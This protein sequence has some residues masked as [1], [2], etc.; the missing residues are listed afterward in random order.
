MADPC[1]V[2]VGENGQIGRT[3]DG[4]DTWASVGPGTNPIVGIPAGYVPE[5]LS[6]DT[7]GGGIWVAVA[8][9]C[10]IWR[11]TDNAATWN[12]VAGTY[13]DN[14]T[15]SPRWQWVCYAGADTWLANETSNTDIWRSTDNGATWSAVTHGV[16]LQ[17]GSRYLWQI[18]ADT[19]NGIVWSTQGGAADY[20]ARSTDRG[21]TWEAVIQNPDNYSD[22]RWLSFVDGK[23]VGASNGSLYISANAA[24]GTWV[25]TIVTDPDVGG[26]MGRIVNDG[27]DFWGVDWG[28]KGIIRNATLASATYDYLDPDG[29]NRSPNDVASDG[30]GVVIYCGNPGSNP[31]TGLYRGNA[32]LTTDSLTLPGGWTGELHAIRYGGGAAPAGV[33]RSWVAW[34]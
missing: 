22:Q 28:G 23:F 11:S 33:T 2:T 30:A 16:D 26:E 10:G 27:T 8:Q 13:T 5:F 31:I 14:D 6:V 21:A 25:N 19:T 34:W 17:G 1:F 20:G 18:A 29:I 15:T 32:D 7:N 12:L 3:L 9:W 4:G 24:T